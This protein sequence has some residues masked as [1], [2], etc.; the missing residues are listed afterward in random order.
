M[1]LASAHRLTD[2]T[3]VSQQGTLVAHDARNRHR[4]RGGDR[5]GRDRRGRAH[6]GATEHQQLGLE[7]HRHTAGQRDADGRAHRVRRRF[8]ANARGRACDRQDR[9]RCRRLTDGLRSHAGGCGREQL[10]NDDRRP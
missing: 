7:P 8:N 9:G 2:R 10:A 3:A 1:D 4:R 6:L 5:Y